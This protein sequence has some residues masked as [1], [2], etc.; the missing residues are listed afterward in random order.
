METRL[1]YLFF[2]ST[3]GICTCLWS[4]NRNY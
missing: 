3:R 1:E 2:S 4:R